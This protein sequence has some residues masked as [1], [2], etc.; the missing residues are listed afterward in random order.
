MYQTLLYYKYTHLENARELAKEHLAFCKEI[1]LTG[2][3]LLSTEGMNGTASGTVEQC[4]QYMDF[5]ES[6]ERFAG[7]EWKIDEVE[8]PSFR[9]MHVRYRKELVA[10][11][12]KNHQLDPNQETGIYLEPEDF[13]KL[14]EQEDVIVLDTRN[15]VEWELGK[16]KNAVTLDI[17]QFREFPEKL[18]ELRQYADKKIIAYCTGGIRCEKATA[19]LLKEGF[20]DVYQLHGGIVRYGKLAGGKDFDGQCYVFDNRIGVE[21]NSV[22]PKI[23]SRCATCGTTTTRM[24][25]CANP[26]CND[27]IVQCLDCSEDMQGTCS[28][29]CYLAPLRRP[30]NE[31]GY[32]MRG[33]EGQPPLQAQKREAVE[34]QMP[35]P[36]REVAYAEVSGKQEEQQED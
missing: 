5:I 17:D 1:G 6:D 34:L 30:Y 28:N 7:I 16:F 9:K 11:N 12:D 4:Q 23:I 32:Y 18:E 31:R 29:S 20:K 36:L 24:I 3:I 33:P 35:L 10:F 14:K 27:H 8:A 22:N 13:Q 21:V 25:N 19:Y 26:S 2:R 15:R